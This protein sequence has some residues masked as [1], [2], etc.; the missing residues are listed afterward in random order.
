[1][2][3]SLRLPALKWTRRWLQQSELMT[4]A[5]I[6]L[7]FKRKFAKK[8]QRRTELTIKS[9]NT[10]WI[11]WIDLVRTG[12]SRPKLPRKLLSLSRPTLRW[13]STAL[14]L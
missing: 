11:W 4:S 12:K 5:N 6:N 7:I 10:K 1:M 3:R 8:K 14:R 9:A 13:S 2:P